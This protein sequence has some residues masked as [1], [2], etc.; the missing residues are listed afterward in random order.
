METLLNAAAG[1][2]GT[3]GSGCVLAAGKRTFTA[4][5]IGLLFALGLFRHRRSL[6][7]YVLLK[8]EGEISWHTNRG[9]SR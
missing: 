3:R 1:P 9:S 6:M 4:W 2:A 7:T 5:S 8:Q